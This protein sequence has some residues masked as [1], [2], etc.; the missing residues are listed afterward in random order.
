MTI[1]FY[2]DK[3]LAENETAIYM[4]VRFGKTTL[5]FKT[6]KRIL[7]K[8][9]NPGTPENHFRKFTGSPE[10]NAWLNRLRTNV[11]KS[12]YSKEQWSI[13]ALKTQITHI[14]NDNVPK[15]TEKEF[16]DALNEFIDSR[17]ANKELANSTIKKYKT[18]ATHLKDFSTKRRYVLSFE[19]VNKK[20]FED[21]SGYLRNELNHTT[22]TVNKYLKTLKTFIHWAV[23]HHYTKAERVSTKFKITDD[24]T[25]VIYLTW[26][27]LMNLYKLEL[28][29][30]SALD[31]AR[32]VFCFGCF[33]GQRFSDISYLKRGD[34][35]GNHWLLH[36][37]K[38][39]DTIQSEIFLNDFARAIL[40][41]YQ[42]DARPLPV[43][44]NQKTNEH[45]KTL[46][47]KAKIN[48]NIKIVKYRGQERIE[49]SEPKY[50][51]LGTHTA[52]RTFITLSLE[53][54]MR[55]ETV[56]A[57]SGHKD[58]KTMKRYIAVT[59][60]MKENEMKIIWTKEIVQTEINHQAG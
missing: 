20:L 47:E 8:Y 49:L 41:K 45:L 12:Y 43:I 22:N 31:H 2:L 28:P 29:A 51:F 4:F 54:G 24:A 14:I 19:R 15:D 30:G 5:K 13:D 57:I 3:P 53:K 40:D 21:F 1:K 60:K 36:Q 55:P 42:N 50:K 9:W 6:G 17:E 34:V 44:S 25:E 33:T 18:M 27:E 16:L 23:D 46:G 58:F 35:L 7:P 11:N 48:T 32:D 26:D 37:I 10:M 39:K 52:R 59:N 38:V 56:M